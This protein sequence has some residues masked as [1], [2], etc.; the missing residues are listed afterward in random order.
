[1]FV[2]PESAG[3]VEVCAV[4]LDGELERD[5]IVTLSTS[6]GSAIGKCIIMYICCYIP[7]NEMLLSG[8][9]GNKMDLVVCQ[10]A[11]IAEHTMLAL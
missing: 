7:T 3:T 5:V 1:M 11:S 10:W 2:L 9:Q 8:K 4:L 6:D